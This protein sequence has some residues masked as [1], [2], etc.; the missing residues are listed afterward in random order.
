VTGG[1]PV[2]IR[3]GEE[4]DLE[5]VH[6]LELVAF[7]DPWPLSAF[8]ELLDQPHVAFEVA[9]SAASE[10][11]GYLIVMRAADEAEIANLAVQPHARRA[12]IAHALL[13]GFLVRA[14]GESVRTM[15]LEV[16]ESNAGARALY[17][18]RGFEQA[19]RRRQYYR[20]PVEDALILRRAL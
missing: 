12:G 5:A 2:R 10:L 4:R 17:A 16:R 15:Y 1:G 11:L 18:S 20:K 14:S 7:A 19:G 13:D 9:E 8:R 6:A 3:P